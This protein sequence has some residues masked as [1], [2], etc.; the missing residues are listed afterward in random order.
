MDMESLMAQAQA[1]QS[2]VADAQ[3][4]LDKTIIK[5][6]ADNGACIVDMNGKYD[7]QKITIRP[8]VLALGA[9]AVEQVVLTALRDAKA[10]ADVQI[11][12]V[13]GD[14]TSGVSLP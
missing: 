5:G 3:A 4:Q 11:D 12:K 14:A 10:K 8:D 2:R 6:I 9:T 1:L 7:I 13:M